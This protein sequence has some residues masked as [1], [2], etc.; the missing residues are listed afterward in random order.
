[1][2]IRWNF[3]VVF[4]LII[5]FLVGL[6]VKASVDGLKFS[7][8]R[9][10]YVE[11]EKSVSVSLRNTSSN[12]YLIQTNMQWLNEKTG[13]SILDKKEKIPFTVVPPLYKLNSD[14]YYSWKI[15]FTGKTKNLP[16]DRESVYLVQ[17]KAIPSTERQN[18][19]SLQFT[20]TRSLLFKVYYRPASLKDVTL[21][22]VSEKLSFHREGHFLVVTNNSPIYA[23][24]DSLSINGSH[25]DSEALFLSVPPFSEQRFYFENLTSGT[26]SWAIMDEYLLPTKKRTST[27]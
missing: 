9:L 21:E 4:I 8:L 23:T 27:I 2:F 3:S 25:V 14:E 20:V 19:E 6:P 22:Q 16:I 10:T 17:L 7:L 24:F 12:P 18:A 26:I 1:M 13:S 15:L 11:G 5:G